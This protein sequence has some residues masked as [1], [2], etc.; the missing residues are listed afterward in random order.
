MDNKLNQNL[1]ITLMSIGLTILNILLVEEFLNIINAIGIQIPNDSVFG[2]V[3]LEVSIL[4]AQIFVVCRYFKT[5]RI[6][7]LGLRSKGRWISQ[8]SYGVL[9]GLIIT[10]FIYSI[11][12]ALRIGIFKG[13]GLI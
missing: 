11:F 2:N 13:S 5:K 1:R 7:A 6:S 3:M 10:V 4:V 9:I 12:F 8:F